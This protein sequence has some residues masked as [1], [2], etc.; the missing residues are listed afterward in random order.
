[1]IVDIFIPCFIDQFYPSTGMNMV[2][3]LEK[4]GVGVNYNT[5]Q[6]CCGQIAYNNGYID[7]A[8]ELGEKFIKD[9]SNNRYVVAPSA[10]CVAM[11]RNY[12]PEMFHNTS[13]HNEYRQ[14]QKNIFE[15]TDFIVNILKV[16]DTASSFTG[17]AV[18]HNSCSSL[19]EYGM[20]SQPKTLL[21][22]IKGLTLID[23]KDSDVCCGFGGSFSIKHP[24]I[25]AAM[26]EQ[27]VAN[28]LECGAEYIISMEALCLMNIENYIKKNNLPL[29]T[30]HIV[31]VLAQD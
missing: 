30:V 14:L 4:F 21:E 6:T 29:K 5:E 31:D 18:L 1:M 9:F 16:T 13:L 23:T 11:V 27:K 10:S 12:Y 28:A 24:D 3:L 7:E 2:K 26:A 8:R 20:K 22:N 17:K 25:S 15:I 19:R